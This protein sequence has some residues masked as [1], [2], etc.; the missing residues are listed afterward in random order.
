MEGSKVIIPEKKVLEDARRLRKE[1]EDKRITKRVKWYILAIIDYFRVLKRLS[2]LEKTIH[3]LLDI[4]RDLF[5]GV[6][7]NHKIIMLLVNG[8]ETESSGETTDPRD[9]YIKELG[10]E[11]KR[12]QKMLNK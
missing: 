4:E 2:G 9:E 3:D 6:E 12:Y 11:I 8:K 1:Y 7:A 10:E 5:K